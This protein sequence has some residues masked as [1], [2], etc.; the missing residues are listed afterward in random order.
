MAILDEHTLDFISHSPEQTRRFGARLGS[1][2]QGG[3]VICL[4]GELGT[5]KTC[6]TQGIGDGLGVSE[7][8]VSPSFTLVAEHRPP[9]ARPILYHVDVYRLASPEVEAWALGLESYLEGV[10]VCVVEWADRI[11]A[12]LPEER[13]WITLRHVGEAK[14]GLTMIASGTRYDE[15]LRQFRESAF[16]Y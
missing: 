9:S 11:R 13:L 3:D 15:L 10:G 16:G 8:I 14:R 4:E 7:P 1:H 12:I 5:G 2:V 6:L